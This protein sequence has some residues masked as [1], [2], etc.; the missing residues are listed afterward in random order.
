M[1]LNMHILLEDLRP[2]DPQS[3]LDDQA[4][5]L[6]ISFP[7]IYNGEFTLLP[8]RLYVARAEQLPASFNID[9]EANLLCI[10]SP[11]IA[12]QDGLNI[13]WIPFPDISIY[14]MFTF[15]AETFN[16]YQEWIESL[17]PTYGNIDALET[18]GA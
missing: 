9:G 10:G 11:A 16:R 15:I 3:R 6:T 5:D 18:I 12:L 14:S 2:Y 7:V 4:M 17:L 8:N 13:I 1:K